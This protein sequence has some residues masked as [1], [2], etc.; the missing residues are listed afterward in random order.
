MGAQDFMDDHPPQ[1]PTATVDRV[2]PTPYVGMRPYSRAEKDWFYGREDDARIIADK[3][4][5]ARLTLLYAPSGVGKSSVLNAGV[6]PALEAEDCCVLYFDGWA[7]DE[8]L[9]AV[10]ERLGAMATAMSV[11]DPLAGAPT[12]SELAR[13]LTA[14]G[15]TLVLIFDQFEEFLV[16]HADQLDPLRKEVAALVR[17]AS[18]DARVLLCLREEFLAALEPFRQSILTLFQSAYRLEA[19]SVADVRKAIVEPA[20]RFGGNVEDALVDALVADLIEGPGLAEV[21]SE[22]RPMLSIAALAGRWRRWLGGRNP[23]PGST[24][25][26]AARER[27]A[28]AATTGVDL[29]MLQLACEQIWMAAQLPDGSRTMTRA[30]YETLGGR[31]RII[32]NHMRACMPVRWRDRLFTAR[33]MRYLAPPSGM[34]ISYSAADLA[35][36]SDLD[37]PRVEAELLRLSAPEARILRRREFHRDVRYELQHDALVRHIAPW[38]DEVLGSATLARRAAWCGAGVAV[39]LGFVGFSAVTHWQQVR[40]NTRDKLA[41]LARMPATTQDVEATD[42]FDLATSYLLNQERG[43]ARL[44]RLKRLLQDFASVLPADYALKTADTGGLVLGLNGTG[45]ETFVLR[46]SPDRSFD[47]EAFALAWAEAAQSLTRRWA[48]PVPPR[49]AAVADADLP[50]N[51]VVLESSGKP[52]VTLELK[53]I[54]E[55]SALLQV[56]GMSGPALEFYRRF[57]TDW[58]KPDDGAAQDWW[59]VPRWSLPVWK[60]ARLPVRAAGAYPAYALEAALDRTP[61]QLVTPAAIRFLI[62]YVAT[63]YPCTAAEAWA[64]RGDSLANDLKRLLNDREAATKAAALGPHLL[65]DLLASVD[66]DT[67]ALALLRQPGGYMLA[68][69]A[70]RKG[71]WPRG[72]ATDDKCALPAH[73]AKAS[74]IA[75]FGAADAWLPPLK[76]KVRIALGSD[77][78]HAWSTAGASE[79]PRRPTAK[80]GTAK[81]AGSAPSSAWRASASATANTVAAHAEPEKS[82]S[83]S[84]LPALGA[85]YERQRRR[86]YLR[87][88]IW[89]P[90]AQF[91]DA[92][93]DGTGDRGRYFRVALLDAQPG[94]GRAADA[95]S[96]DDAGLDRLMDQLNQAT[97]PLAPA[98]IDAEYVGAL[99]RNNDTL[100]PLIADG[101]MPSLTDLSLLLREV[102]GVQPLEPDAVAARSGRT[103]RDPTWLLQ[104][105]VFWRSFYQNGER[106]NMPADLMSDLAGRLRD[107]QARKAAPPAALSTGPAA[108][109]IERGIDALLAGQFQ[110]ADQQFERATKT[111]PYAQV[112]ALFAERYAARWGESLRRR[113][114]S[115]CS[116]KLDKAG[117]PSKSDDPFK[118]S[119]GI[120]EYPMLQQELRMWLPAQPGE[121]D[122][123]RSRSLAM[124]LLASMPPGRD[125]DRNALLLDSA[126]RYGDPGKWPPE[127]AWWLALEMLRQYDPLRATPG[128]L[129]QGGRFMESAAA[130]FAPS[131]AG[132]AESELQSICDLPGPKNWCLRQLSR[133]A[134]ATA[135]PWAAL[136][137]TLLQLERPDGV[138]EALQ[139]LDRALELERRHPV[140]RITR[141]QFDFFAL[142]ARLT[143]RAELGE[144]PT[145]AETDQLLQL[146]TS[147]DDNASTTAN[148]FAVQ[149][150]LQADLPDRERSLKL[151]RRLLS[152][153]QMLPGALSTAASAG[154]RWA[155]V[156]LV[157][158]AV[159]MAFDEAQTSPDKHSASDFLFVAA[160]AGLVTRHKDAATAAGQFISGD[161]NY[162][163]VVAILLRTRAD[164]RLRAVAERRLTELWRSVDMRSWDARLRAGD[165][166]AWYEMLLGYFRGEVE[167]AALFGP[168]HDDATFQASA[169]AELGITRANALTEANFYD[170]LRRQTEGDAAGAR[171]SLQRVVE[172]GTRSYVEYSMAL[173]LLRDTNP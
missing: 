105:L 57:A 75:T 50:A 133:Y 118:P 74:D 42:R 128:L 59:I 25:A 117:V 76:G 20:K 157:K 72:S 37:R 145:S 135:S 110:L 123:Q 137:L 165:N 90:D 14:T 68:L 98:L 122:P 129:D 115:L 49:I 16:T 169:L 142:W 8:P 78:V 93:A 171:A 71:N 114:Q 155:D 26:G 61:S 67:G 89:L 113:A 104:S 172:S 159:D 136:E 7:G 94:S 116:P 81:T 96:T 88:G 85:A 121:R 52:L 38:R 15:K 12:L 22:A 19:L 149:Q 140:P 120:A 143:A 29:P 51:E 119:V 126:T 161:D 103:L 162:A 79:E 173:Q 83:T 130:R 127:Q 107:L 27:P 31:D 66:D 91:I 18:I 153:K 101:T 99:L 47:K 167:Q 125:P 41:E 64:R 146:G 148:I 158:L 106:A 13:L 24:G 151:A 73:F 17:T 2:G 60:S 108:A 32:K 134:T 124:C 35:S 70:T 69:S 45:G 102:V 87:T 141:H 9:S 5:A 30:L 54:D 86:W 28:P 10:K 166:R 92:G 36:Y 43:D 97:A 84:A 150:A 21:A 164:E 132:E 139:S 168:L 156:E 53:P 46:Y 34:K 39:L 80:A 62:Q 144:A 138:R 55:S 1:R 3:T 82:M 152:A 131:R 33:L 65:L 154:L 160:Y 170:A 40:H 77:L 6:L 44:D 11:A 95:G 163:P 111:G 48:I 23:A 56:N 63:R 4:L 100:K 112:P 147:I 58:V 109:A